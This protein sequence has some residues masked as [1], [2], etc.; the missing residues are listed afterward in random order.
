LGTPTPGAGMSSTYF[1]G[2][3]RSDV[4][5]NGGTI[6]PAH[7]TYLQFDDGVFQNFIPQLKQL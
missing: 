6:G 3:Y 4:R 1:I 7:S 2:N 5:Q